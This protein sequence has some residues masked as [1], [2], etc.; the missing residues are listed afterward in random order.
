MTETKTNEGM[1]LGNVYYCVKCNRFTDVNYLR[2]KV[3]KTQRIKA[4]CYLC[5]NEF[6]L[7]RVSDKVVLIEEIGELKEQIAY[8]GEWVAKCKKECKPLGNER[9]RGELLGY[10]TIE[11]IIKNSKNKERRE[12]DKKLD[13]RKNGSRQIRILS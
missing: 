9:E 2:D 8:I 7:E 11:C 5:N 10:K 13:K 3:N 6:P 1:D 4:Y 12:Y